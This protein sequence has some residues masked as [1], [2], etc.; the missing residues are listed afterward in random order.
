[1]N[2]QDIVVAALLIFAC[3]IGGIGI[4]GLFFTETFPHLIN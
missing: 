1:M 2:G 3:L 4:V